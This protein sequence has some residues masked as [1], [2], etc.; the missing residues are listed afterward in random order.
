MES[1]ENPIT[2]ENIR[3]IK[4]KTKTPNVNVEQIKIECKGKERDRIVALC[5]ECGSKKTRF[6]NASQPIKEK[7]KPK[8]N[9]PKQSQV[10]KYV[11]VSDLPT[12]FSKL[13]NE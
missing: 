8:K 9:I 5:Q 3:C 13:L 10:D 7:P 4:C 11:K 12:L 2:V 6:G 1:I